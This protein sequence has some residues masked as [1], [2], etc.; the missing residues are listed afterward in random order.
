MEIKLLPLSLAV[1]SAVPADNRGV[2]ED[3]SVPE[4]ASHAA[5]GQGTDQVTLSVYV[6]ET[7]RIR[8]AHGFPSFPPLLTRE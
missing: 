4:A 1:H 2:L 8:G 7:V 5:G 6:M 3:I